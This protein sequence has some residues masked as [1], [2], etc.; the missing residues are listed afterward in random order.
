MSIG[1]IDLIILLAAAQGFFLSVLIFHKHGQLFAN[2][3]LVALI[4]L[5]SLLLLNLLIGDVDFSETY[6]H[7]V[8][9]I[10]GLAFFMIPLHY[11][12]AKY[13]MQRTGRFNPSDWLH[14]VPFLLWEGFSL[15]GI[16]AWPDRTRFWARLIGSAPQEV[17]FILFHWLIIF[18][19]GLY[20][21]I[22]IH[23][24]HRYSRDIKA[25]FSST[26]KIRLDWLTY[27]TYMAL[28]VII[29]FFI[30][31]LFLL[32]GINL[33]G[34]FTLSSV[35]VAVYVYAI[36]YLGLF[37]SEVFA[38]PG[39]AASL[40]RLPELT[41]PASRETDFSAGS[42]EKYEKSGLTPEKA[43]EYKKQLL[44]LME[45]EAPYLEEDLTLGSL[46]DRLSISPHNLSEVI[47]TGLGQ[48]FFDF[49]NHYR[50]ESAKDDL[51]DPKKQHLKILAVAYEAGFN[52][53]SSFY[54]IFKKHTGLTPAEYRSR[55]G[56]K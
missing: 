12:Y 4:L 52:S 25:V 34:N 28:A 38:L 9:F 53:K 31:N 7:L 39:I 16:F 6:Y 17:G 26:E 2:R 3:F 22:T 5:Y 15:V 44:D 14:F 37:K 24:L 56:P 1:L 13:L 45:K 10:V 55:F 19:G 23:A 33:T 40:R 35:L 47:N 18:Q 21:F 11:L 54:A 49:V 41:T 43:D 8:P 42:Q 20:M 51:T 32:G 30:E 36:G 29:I 48:N 50:V 46:A 27:I